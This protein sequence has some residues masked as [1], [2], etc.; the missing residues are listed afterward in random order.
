MKRETFAKFMFVR[1]SRLLW[2]KKRENCSNFFFKHLQ[3]HS[4]RL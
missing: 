3:F 2:Q 1:Q 4:E